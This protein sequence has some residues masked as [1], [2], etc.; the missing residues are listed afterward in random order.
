MYKKC[1][2]FV[3]VYKGVVFVVEKRMR[4]FVCVSA[5]RL[6][7]RTRK[8][9]KLIGYNSGETEQA[10]ATPVGVVRVRVFWLKKYDYS[11]AK[12]QT[13]FIIIIIV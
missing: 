7:S 10:E 1:I 2:K 4:L 9:V 8:S 11:Q 5:A 13:S 3:Y 6:R 12:A